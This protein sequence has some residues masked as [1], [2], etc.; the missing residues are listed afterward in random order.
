MNGHSYHDNTTK[1]CILYDGCERCSEHATHPID[2]LDNE[3]L[4]WLW[5]KMIKMEFDEKKGLHYASVAERMAAQ[6]LYPF[7]ILLLK[8]GYEPVAFPMELALT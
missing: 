8:F 3:H 7:A 5:I 2:S 1:D 4:Q 6:K